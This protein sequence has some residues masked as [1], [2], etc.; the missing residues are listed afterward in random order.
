M[1]QHN[2]EIYVNWIAHAVFTED[3][4]GHMEVLKIST[5]TSYL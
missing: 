1:S 2:R 5:T 3:V 4:T